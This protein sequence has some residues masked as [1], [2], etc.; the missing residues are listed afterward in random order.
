[1]GFHSLRVGQVINKQAGHAGNGDLTAVGT[2]APMD[3]G[4]EHKV[5]PQKP[6]CHLSS[7]AF[8]FDGNE[9]RLL[10]AVVK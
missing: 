10:F 5:F 8:M 2:A 6:A 9:E 4:R 3:H 7:H 1:M